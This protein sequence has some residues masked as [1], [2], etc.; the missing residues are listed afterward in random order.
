MTP[1]RMAAAVVGVLALG[2]CNE[3]ERGR[4]LFFTG[5]YQGEVRPALTPDMRET[6]ARRAEYQ[7]GPSSTAVGARPSAGAASGGAAAT[8]ARPGG[9][10]WGAGASVRVGDGS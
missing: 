9:S 2:A 3:D 5:A 6:L 7:R 1:S 4:P 10:P 8:A